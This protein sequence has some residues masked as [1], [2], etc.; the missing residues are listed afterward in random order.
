VQAFYAVSGFYMTLVLHE[1]YI[2]QGSYG[3]FLR[4]R[5]L[6][7]APLYVA[8]AGAT[9]VTALLFQAGGLG[10]FPP[11]AAWQAAGASLPPADAA[12][13]VAS[14]ALLVG[15]D[16]LCFTVLD[17]ATG[18]LG[19][20]ADAFGHAPHGTPVAPAQQVWRLLFVPQAWTVCVELMFYVLAPL[21]VRRPTWLLASLALLS[22]LARAW[23]IRTTGVG[24]DPW[25]YRFFPFELA[26]FLLGALACRAYFA[27]RARD[28]LPRPACLAALAA[29]LALPF[30]APHLGDA[31][32]K[33][34]Y[35]AP[36]LVP[37]LACLLPFVF[38][39]TRDS[40]IDRAIGELS[41][42]VYLVHFL[43]VY[44]V[45]AADSPWLT[46]HRGEV[47]ATA[48]LLLAALLWRGV[49]APMERRRAAFM[50]R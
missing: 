3:T 30:A 39:A 2:G 12:L 37:L 21:L 6:R 24:W 32:W 43:C 25:T 42:P 15:Q 33:G 28:L 10:V 14:N 18:G 19:W 26:H 9:L 29:A 1:K 48:S 41:Y 34:W 16:A 44:A 50:P 47:V 36:G 13:L 40:R 38:A 35:A 20:H 4:A 11:L 17:P 45:D 23:T 46:A 49:G 22:Y 27:L 7:L 31:V 8:A 5:L